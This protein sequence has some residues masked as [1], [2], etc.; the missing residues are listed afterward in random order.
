MFSLV[1]L[2]LVAGWGGLVWISSNWF[3]HTSRQQDFGNNE[4]FQCRISTLVRNR[5]DGPQDFVIL[6][7]YSMCC[8]D[9]A[10]STVIQTGHIVIHT[11]VEPHG[12]WHSPTMTSR[13]ETL[14]SHFPAAL[15]VIHHR[16]ALY[17]SLEACIQ[18]A[19]CKENWHANFQHR[20]SHWELNF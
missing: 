1:C 19:A 5:R 3:N 7:L 11:G 2:G 20:H 13:D 4:R 16:N 12:S 14:C 8:I 17:L 15:F 6:L 10:Y 18:V 9:S